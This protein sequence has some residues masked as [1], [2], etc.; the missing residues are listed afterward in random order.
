MNKL[1]TLAILA[2]LIPHAN[3]SK[4]ED[5]DHDKL[6]F[7]DSMQKCWSSWKRPESE[8][9]FRFDEKTGY[10][11]PGSLL[12]ELANS[13]QKKDS[14]CFLKRFKVSPG[15]EYT[16]IVWIKTENLDAG[17]EVSL[18]FQYQDA[19]KKFLKLPLNKTLTKVNDK[20]TSW[21]RLVLT[22]RI[23]ENGK[24]AEVKNLLCTLGVKNTTK[25]KVWFD[26][27]EIFEN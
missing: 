17:A 1:H 10:Q 7:K 25:G 5:A 11:K 12:I 16:A 14:G 20:K 2:L 13:N 15:K 18:T 8:C 22:S 4:A 19:N 27:F 26:D 21:K 23:S 3:I 24:W 6:E 9:S